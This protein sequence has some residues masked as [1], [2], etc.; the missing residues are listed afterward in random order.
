V[1]PPCTFNNVLVEVDAGSDFPCVVQP[2]S[3]FPD[4]IIP[5]TL[6]QGGGV[7]AVR[8]VNIT[9]KYVLLKPGSVIGTAVEAIGIVEKEDQAVVTEAIFSSGS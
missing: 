6:V 5:A 8:V 2:N 1:I 9:N 4:L 3:F 7:C